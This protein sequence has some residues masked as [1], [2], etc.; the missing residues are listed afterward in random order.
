MRHSPIAGPRRVPS[1]RALRDTPTH[2]F[3]LP[4]LDYDDGA[5]R[6]SQEALEVTRPGRRARMRRVRW[7]AVGLALGTVVAAMSQGGAQ[8][9]C[10]ALR[11]PKASGH[12]SI[13]QTSVTVPEGPT[14]AP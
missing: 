14:P 1:P 12:G 3:P 10:E 5:S 6:R 11:S 2:V 9:T 7:F 8:A 4:A 13:E